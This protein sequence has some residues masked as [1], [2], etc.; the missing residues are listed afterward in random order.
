L[1]SFLQR[2]EYIIAGNNDVSELRHSALNFDLYTHFTSPLRR[3]PDMVVHRQVKYILENKNKSNEEI[4][5]KDFSNISYESYVDHFNEKYYNSKLIS[6]RSQK[7]FQCILLRGS[8]TKTYKGLILDINYKSMK[9]N[10]R[11]PVMNTMQTSES[12]LL[13][14]IFIEELNLEIVYFIFYNTLGME[15][16]R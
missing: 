5:S 11:G 3:Y 16:R 10:K 7:V 9:P 4:N 2:A 15:K 8:E 13:I 6:L 12:S 1:R 14:L